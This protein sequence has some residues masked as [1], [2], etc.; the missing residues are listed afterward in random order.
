VYTYMCVNMCKYVYIYDY[1]YMCGIVWVEV[2]LT[3]LVAVPRIS[4]VNPGTSTVRM[5]R[6]QTYVLRMYAPAASWLIHTPLFMFMRQPS[7]RDTRTHVRARVSRERS[8]AR[9]PNRR[10]Y[11]HRHTYN[12]KD[13]SILTGIP[14]PH[15][16]AHTTMTTAR[17]DGQ[18][19]NDCS[20]RPPRSYSKRT[21]QTVVTSRPS[22]RAVTIATLAQTRY[23]YIEKVE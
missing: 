2:T 15:V 4:N 13:P 10:V 12:V 23:I 1:G 17:N 14:T 18:L 21:K 16:C 20:P 11:E 6:S 8:S 9:T 3:R 5:P 22:L 19:S 7:P